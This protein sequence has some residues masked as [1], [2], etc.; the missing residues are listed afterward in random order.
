[1]STGTTTPADRPVPESLEGV[2]AELQRLAPAMVDL[3]VA[4]LALRL[5]GDPQAGLPSRAEE[6]LD[7]LRRTGWLTPASSPG[8]WLLSPGRRSAAR[9]AA[10]LS[11]LQALISS[12]TRASM[13]VA[14]ESAAFRRGLAP[15]PPWREVIA[16]GSGALKDRAPASCRLVRLDLGAR[17]VTL[18]EGLPV[19]TVEALLVSLS[20]KP[21]GYVGWPHVGLWLSRAVECLVEAAQ[22]SGATAATEISETTD[23]LPG[24]AVGVPGVVELLGGA[25]ASAWARAAYLLRAGGAPEA[26]GV[27]LAAAPLRLTGTVYLGPSHRPGTYDSVTGVWDTLLGCA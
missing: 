11:E 4:R 18:H 3:G 16:V 7:G 26:A 25:P 17:S 24:P 6:V 19:H 9:T 2:L 14:M 22:V 20:V 23:V 8:L 1:M 10:A 21:G 5:T 15:D 27:V 13:A 12:G